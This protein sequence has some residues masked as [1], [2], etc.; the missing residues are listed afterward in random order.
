MLILAF[1]AISHSSEK[2]GL[3]LMK[4][5][6]EMIQN[7]IYPKTQSCFF[8]FSFRATLFVSLMNA[9]VVIDLGIH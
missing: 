4:S 6:T 7:F 3:C 9:L 2:G 5:S 8:R 1:E